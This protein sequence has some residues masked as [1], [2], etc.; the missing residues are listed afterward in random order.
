MIVGH[1]LARLAGLPK[2]APALHIYLPCMVEILVLG[3][4]VLV[5]GLEG[6]VTG[7]A[8][9]AFAPQTVCGLVDEGA[10]VPLPFC[11]CTVSPI[12]VAVF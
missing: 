1:A 4:A 6:R 11:P 10:L 7:L 3:V 9:R 12:P 5:R 2:T 8:S